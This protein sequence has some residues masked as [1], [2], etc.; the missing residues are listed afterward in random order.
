MYA[1]FGAAGLTGIL[2]LV[3][4]GTI[5]G[6]SAPAVPPVSEPDP[7][8]TD[9]QTITDPGL[10]VPAERPQSGFGGSP[11]AISGGS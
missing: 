2:M 5:P 11:V 6:N 9:P 4:A 3:A 7:A 8:A 10:S 1:A